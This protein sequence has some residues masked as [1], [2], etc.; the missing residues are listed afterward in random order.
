MIGAYLAISV[1]KQSIIPIWQ[2]KIILSYVNQK[3]LKEYLSLSNIYN[4]KKKLCTSELI[5]LI[6]NGNPKNNVEKINTELSIDEFNEILIIINLLWIWWHFLS[7][8]VIL[9]DLT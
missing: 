3:A 4:N 5:D 6:I 2:L 1:L 8:I 9:I 7:Y